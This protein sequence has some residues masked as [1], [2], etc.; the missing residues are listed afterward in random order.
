M[1]KLIFTILFLL[2]TFYF[3]LSPALGFSITQPPNS[4][5]RSE[6]D[7]GVIV[8]MVLSNILAIIFIIAAIVVIFM[9]IWGAFEWITSGGDKEAVGK[10]RKRITTSLL[11][12][13]FLALAYLIAYNVGQL[14]NIDL[15]GP[16]QIPTLGSPIQQR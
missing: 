1:P 13:V 9:I 16:M 8:S 7:I 4:G 12:L 3:P 14:I 11:G 15:L 2:F 5:V 6:G 10:A